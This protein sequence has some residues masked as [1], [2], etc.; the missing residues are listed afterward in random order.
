VKVG[1]YLWQFLIKVD[2]KN[3]TI[4]QLTRLVIVTRRAVIRS[5]A[6][7]KAP[8]WRSPRR[9]HRRGGVLPRPHGQRAGQQ[10]PPLVCGEALQVVASAPIPRKS[11]SSIG[12]ASCGRAERRGGRPTRGTKGREARACHEQDQEACCHDS[13]RGRGWGPGRSSGGGEGG[14]GGVDATRGGA[15]GAGGEGNKGNKGNEGQGGQ[16][17]VSEDEGR[18][19]KILLSTS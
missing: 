6:G 4:D 14:G 18:A 5:S 3:L 8:R 12:A 19:W 10:P 9:E 13:H 17:G 2:R 1:S 7:E 15:R 16:G 11:G